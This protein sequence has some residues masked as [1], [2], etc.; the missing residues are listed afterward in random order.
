MGK[1][2]Y[3]EKQSFELRFEK[4]IKVQTHNN[5]NNRNTNLPTR[6]CTTEHTLYTLVECVRQMKEMVGKTESKRENIVGDRRRA[7]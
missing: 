4:E 1:G 6:G 2:G 5:N 3:G 7:L